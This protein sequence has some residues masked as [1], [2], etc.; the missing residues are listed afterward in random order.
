LINTLK[1]FGVAAAIAGTLTSASAQDYPNRPVRFIVPH[2]AGGGTDVVARVFAQKMSTGLGQ[3][4]VVE[5]KV[6]GG[7]QVGAEYVSSAPA[8]G[9]TVLFASSS[10]LTLPYLRNTKYELSRDFV[11]IGEVGSG[12][13]ALVVSPNFPARTLAEFIAVAKAKPS[14]YTYGSAGVGSANHLAGELL[15]SRVGIDVR[16]IPYKSSGEMSQALMAGQIDSSIDVL[17]TEKELI[18]TGKVRALATTGP[19]RDADFPNVPTM[20]EGK[21]VPGGYEMTFWFGVFVPVKTPAAVVERLRREFAVAM[22]DPEVIRRVK[23]FSLKPSTSTPAQ[24]QAAIIAE[25]IVWK[26]VIT[27]NGI[28]LD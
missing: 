10:I 2:G 8:D 1:A 11:P 5:N 17:I 28:R 18:N 20:N 13:F 26:K 12:N 21:L 23:S 24:F 14:Q 25:Q 19:E 9:Y 3:A 15:K 7:S 16:H 22:K 27:D 6:G 4:V